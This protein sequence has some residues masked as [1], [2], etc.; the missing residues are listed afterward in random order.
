MEIDK[1]LQYDV[2]ELNTSNAKCIPNEMS[3][4]CQLFP[5]K[6]K[7]FYSIRIDFYIVIIH[8]PIKQR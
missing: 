7:T 1:D 4:E 8:K 6:L 3:S 5:N 2:K